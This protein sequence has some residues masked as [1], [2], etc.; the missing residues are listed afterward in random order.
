MSMLGESRKIGD[1][2]HA[3]IVAFGGRGDAAGNDYHNGR[4]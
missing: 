4:P 1:V 2:H 3:T